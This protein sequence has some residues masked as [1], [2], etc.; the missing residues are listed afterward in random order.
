MWGPRTRLLSHS[1][2]HTFT[3]T[4]SLARS[5]APPWCPSQ[6]KH[7]G[8]PVCAHRHAHRE[9]REAEKKGGR[10]DTQREGRGGGRGRGRQGSMDIRVPGPMMPEMMLRCAA[11]P[12]AELAL[13]STAARPGPNCSL[14]SLYAPLS[15]PLS[16][17]LCACACLHRRTRP[18]CHRACF[19]SCLAGSWTATWSTAA[20]FSSSGAPGTDPCATAVACLPPARCHGP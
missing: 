1:F 15:L 17:C 13:V 11:V 9:N 4:P 6:R 12:G 18:L 10:T 20:S 16:L 3:A 7:C 19:T 2:L 5:R 8:R 14:L